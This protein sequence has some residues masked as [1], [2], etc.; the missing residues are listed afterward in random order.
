MILDKSNIINA[1]FSNL[2]ADE[3]RKVKG[4]SHAFYDRATEYL[5]GHLENENFHLNRVI[6]P[7]D[8]IQREQKIEFC[9]KSLQALICSISEGEEGKSEN[10]HKFNN[11]MEKIRSAVQSNLGL[12]RVQ[13]ETYETFHPI[14]VKLGA[15]NFPI[16]D[17]GELD[18]GS[19][20]YR[21]D[22]VKG[23]DE[24]NHHG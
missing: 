4:V 11:M 13:R 24:R 12:S 7:S 8:A 21:T 16:N 2:S 15:P 18:P 20:V 1:I 22:H 19:I 17:E 6:P 3:I 14:Y 23:R 5:T 9:A 10:L